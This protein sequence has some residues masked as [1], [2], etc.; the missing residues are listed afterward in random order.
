MANI[1]ALYAE[2]ERLCASGADGDKIAKA[3]DKI[4]KVDPNAQ[5]ARH[6]KAV[7]YLRADQ[8]DEA[9]QILETL[10]VEEYAYEKAYALY[11]VHRLDDALSVVQEAL[12]NVDSKPQG[13]KK[14]LRILEAQL[15]YRME[16]FGASV[17]IY[18]E[19]IKDLDLD[20]P[21]YN[22]V[23]VNYTAAKS[24]ARLDYVPG[25]DSKLPKT[26]IQMYEMTYNLACMALASGNLKEATQLLEKS[27]KQCRDVLLSESY[28]EE[29]IE[30]E[31]AIIV[32]QLGY[33]YQL[34]GREGE[35]LDLYQGILKSKVADVAIT[36][37]VSNN[38]NAIK[39]DKDLF[40]SQKRQKI[41]TAA[42]GEKLTQTQLKII[43]MNGALLS[44]YA[45]SPVATK[46]QAKKLAEQYP[47][48]HLPPLILAAVST[49]NAKNP[50]KAADELEEY[51]K[52]YPTNLGF[53][54][55]L[56]QIQI[57]QLNFSAA[58]QIMNDYFGVVDKSLQYQPALVSLMVWLYGRVDQVDKAVEWLESATQN[59]NSSSEEVED[60][61]TLKQ[62]AA[63]KLKSHRARDAAKDYERLVRLDPS[64]TCAI[65]GL[66]MA[67]AEFDLASAEKYS[68]SLGNVGWVDEDPDISREQPVD[69]EKLESSFSWSKKPAAQPSSELAEDIATR[70]Q[71]KP[72]KKRKRKVRLPKNYDPNVSP[73]PERWLPKYERSAFLRKVGKRKEKEKDIG[74]GPQGAAVTGGGLGGTGSANIFGLKQPAAAQSPPAPLSPQLSEAEK[75]PKTPAS[76]AA[77]AAKKKNKKKK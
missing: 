10:P 21:Y 22:E 66:V 71:L 25:V 75:T 9:L 23:H 36:A 37:V 72:K 61:W 27:R 53:R 77:T 65:A 46:E 44:F 68:A 67:Y 56:C 11:R 24:A 52:K 43:S 5:D 64:D 32:A 59:W 39:R 58:I 47:D 20:D 29:E 63:F 42:G 8:Y 15:L 73:D 48:D 69:V 62:L 4:L 57:N 2:L 13:A 7:V 16:D 1:K 60:T 6:V 19:I 14:A 33:I 3:A 38:V 34:Q 55:V 51:V 12:A 17:K 50:R 49:K 40:D 54:L 31:L 74:R 45:K 18:D 28:G 30:Q 35:A 76:V 41:A 26:S 70:D